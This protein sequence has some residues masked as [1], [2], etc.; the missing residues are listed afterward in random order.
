MP[1]APFVTLRAP[2]SSGRKALGADETLTDGEKNFVHTNRIPAA[3][4]FAVMKR[5]A[6]HSLYEQTLFAR[7]RSIPE[8]SFP[9]VGGRKG[10]FQ[11]GNHEA[12]VTRFP[13]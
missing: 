7:S 11:G 1:Q 3:L 9:P 2:P 10:D 8:T 12:L 5:S 6:L 13:P 4:G